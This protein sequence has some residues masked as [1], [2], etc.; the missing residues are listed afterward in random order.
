MNIST[1][2][3]EINQS[4]YDKIRDLVDTKLFNILDGIEFIDKNHPFTHYLKGLT[5]LYD[6]TIYLNI[7]HGWYHKETTT[8]N[9]LVKYPGK[10]GCIIL[11]AWQQFIGSKN[12]NVYIYGR[13]CGAIYESNEY[14]TDIKY[15]YKNII[16]KLVDKL[17]DD[18]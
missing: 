8:A 11:H 7:L 2:I 3:E 18:V 9:F 6:D 12:A 5:V 1:I 16:K 14:E 17:V 10:T 15:F 13:Y 4:D